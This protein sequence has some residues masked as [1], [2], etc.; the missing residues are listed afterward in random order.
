VRAPASFLDGQ[1]TSEYYFPVLI[2]GSSPV[3]R[4]S[5]LRI[6]SAAQPF[7][8][9][10]FI[11]VNDF[12]KTALFST[13]SCIETSQSTVPFGRHSF[14]WHVIPRPGLLDSFFVNFLRPPEAGVGNVGICEFGIIQIGCANF[15][16]GQ[17]SFVKFYVHNLCSNET[18]VA[19]LSEREVGVV[20]ICVIKNCICQICSVHL[21]KAEVRRIQF[22]SAEIKRFQINRRQVGTRQI[23]P[24]ILLNFRP[25]CQLHARSQPVCA[26]KSFE[27]IALQWLKTWTFYCG[28]VLFDFF[29]ALLGVLPH[30]I[31]KQIQDQI[32]RFV[33]IAPN[34][35]PEGIYAGKA[36]GDILA[37]QHLCTFLI[38]IYD[39]ALF[40]KLMRLMGDQRPPKSNSSSEYAKRY[41]A[42]V[43]DVLE[44]SLW[45][46]R[47]EVD[48]KFR[49]AFFY[50]KP[51]DVPAMEHQRP[52]KWSNDYK[53][54]ARNHDCCSCLKP[55][56]VAPPAIKP[57]IEA[58]PFFLEAASCDHQPQLS[59]AGNTGKHNFTFPL[60]ISSIQS[61]T[62]QGC[63][64][65]ARVFA[66]KGIGGVVA[67][68]G[69]RLIAHDYTHSFEC[70]LILPRHV[71]HTV[72]GM[73]EPE[74]ILFNQS[75]MEF[76]FPGGNL[77]R[78]KL[79]DGT[80]PD[81]NPVVPAYPE[82]TRR[83][84]FA[85]LEMKA[86]LDRMSRLAG[87]RIRGVS[88]SAN[89]NGDLLFVTMNGMDG[90]ECAERISSGA[91]E[92]WPGGAEVYG[93]NASYLA[94]LCRLYRHAALISFIA[95]DAGSP[96]LVGPDE[97]WGQTVLMPM[98][99]VGDKLFRT[100]LLEFAIAANAKVS[101]GGDCVTVI[102]AGTD[103][104]GQ[105]MEAAE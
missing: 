73:V 103:P 17:I 23:W 86:A 56:D 41:H 90:K 26:F 77:L 79:I 59:A 38:S 78:S 18:G 83:L 36:D 35:L 28:I 12:Q 70:Y 21:R 58:P 24:P 74:E 15:S 8:K 25:F 80:F 46:L 52:N 53:S 32:I 57:F 33:R 96:T 98:R 30:K 62:R 99:V 16:R 7:I 68:D 85:T 6:V 88:N 45:F 89:A 65:T 50:G 29:R 92:H 43:S 13:A 14:W 51:S 97:T 31:V 101:G 104:A 54:R 81:W 102:I 11:R 105:M 60:H 1:I 48:K 82:D 66:L 84:S 20:T 40:G 72:L 67:T 19:K 5:T 34:Q 93:F 49:G 100:A 44:N 64:R 37:F 39:Q 61:S 3:Q 75:Y 71:V 27:H 69:H 91:A 10:Q 2:S 95:P 87:S 94:D 76:R 22:C 9:R 42:K 4:R 63:N 47:S 55:S